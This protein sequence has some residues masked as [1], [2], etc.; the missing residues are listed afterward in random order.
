M[1]GAISTQGNFLFAD[2]DT[3]HSHLV[4]VLVCRMRKSPIGSGPKSNSALSLLSHPTTHGWLFYLSGLPSLPHSQQPLLYSLL[5]QFHYL[6][7]HPQQD[8]TALKQHTTFTMQSMS[9]ANCG[10]GKASVS[11]HASHVCLSNIAI[12]RANANGT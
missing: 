11:R 5:Q 8:D 3:L 1:V 9:C 2:I 6:L 10:R 12:L 7:P 4:A